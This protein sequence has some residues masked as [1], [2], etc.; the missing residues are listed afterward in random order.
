[1]WIQSFFSSIHAK[2]MQTIYCSKPHNQLGSL[3]FKLLIDMHCWKHMEDNLSSF[4][5]NKQAPDR[6]KKNQL[7]IC[8]LSNCKVTVS[9]TAT[10]KYNTFIF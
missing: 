5:V 2:A 6:P 4:N 7:L 8:T 3:H 10:E 1:M 9:T